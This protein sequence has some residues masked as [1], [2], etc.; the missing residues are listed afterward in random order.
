METLVVGEIVQDRAGTPIDSCLQNFSRRSC[1]I[2][3]SIMFSDSS[4][5][6]SPIKYSI[7]V[8]T[9]K[10]TEQPRCCLR[11]VTSVVASHSGS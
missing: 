1:V 10:L 6:G 3:S 11:I 2:G 5:A 7:L 9:G 4:S 8:R